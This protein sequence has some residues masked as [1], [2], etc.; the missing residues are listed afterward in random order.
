LF[1]IE[2]FYN[3]YDIPYFTEGK[4]VQDGWI[5]VRCPFCYDSSNHLGFNLAKD[6]YNCWKCGRHKHY[7]VIEF[8]T[9]LKAY[10]IFK[11]LNEYK[12]ENICKEKLK[13]KE[14]SSIFNIPKE[15]KS[16][17]RIHKQYLS[18]RNYDA[19]F[20]EMKYGLKATGHLGDYAFR[21][22]IPIYYEDKIVSFTAR[23]YTDKQEIRY[24]SCKKENETIYHK[25]ILYNLDNCKEDWCI[26]VEGPFDVFRMGDNCCATFGTGFTYQQIKLL[27]KRFKYVM[28][29]FDREKEAQRQAK[30]MGNNLSALGIK[31]NILNLEFKDPGEF[32]QQLVN[33]IK[34]QVQFIRRII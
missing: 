9:G 12:T 5:N 20:L 30:M 33:E 6:Y 15:W 1:D 24:K 14:K 18:R 16:L 4:N 31:I 26:V 17:K 23:D 27:S 10:Q 3:D 22:A 8:L 25:T 13:N 34:E 28:I 32:N 7:E 2:R 29:I 11:I 21:I 19:D